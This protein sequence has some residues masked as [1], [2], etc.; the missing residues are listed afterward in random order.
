MVN[1]GQYQMKQTCQ[2]VQPLLL[3]APSGSL[4]LVFFVLLVKQWLAGDGL[5]LANSYSFE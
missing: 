3:P 2:K 1:D 5:T 4:R